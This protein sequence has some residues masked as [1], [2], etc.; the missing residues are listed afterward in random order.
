VLEEVKKVRQ[1]P[2]EGFRR[3][4]RSPQMD[5]FLWYDEEEKTRI[6]GF[7]LCH[8]NKDRE[9]AL[10][11]RMG[12]GLS[13]QG[14]DD[15]DTPGNMKETPILTEESEPY[16]LEKIRNE[17]SQISGKVE[18]HLRQGILSVLDGKKGF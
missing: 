18:E 5:L 1:I 3:W 6:L 15:G 10:T 17:F 13:F 16:D 2:G 9:S 12:E 11:W 8:R 7:Q 4:F 14:V